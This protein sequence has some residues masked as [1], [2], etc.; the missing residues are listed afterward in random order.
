MYRIGAAARLT[1]LSIDTIRFYEK[2][3]LI[4]PGGQNASGYRLFT[5]SNLLTFK[6]IIKSRSMGFSLR[7]IHDLLNWR[8]NPARACISVR[9]LIEKKLLQ[10]RQKV[11]YFRKLEC[12]LAQDL[13]SC[14]QH[15]K[16]R[17]AVKSSCPVLERIAG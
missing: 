3:G 2:I 17:S 15:L 5:E 7:E 11:E 4:K 12:Q 14:N 9:E 1:G 10:I 8:Q 13:D 6:F 16:R